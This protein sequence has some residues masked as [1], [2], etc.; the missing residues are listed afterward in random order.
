LYKKT[1]IIFFLITSF[2]AF[3]ANAEES[4]NYLLTAASK[5]DLDTVSAILESG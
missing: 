1:L 4:V 2:F 3:I 5:G